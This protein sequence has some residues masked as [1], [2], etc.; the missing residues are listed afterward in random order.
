VFRKVRLD[1]LDEDAD[2]LAYWKTRTPAERISEV[3]SLR[4]LWIEV[5]DDPD[6]P[7]ELVAHRRRLGEPAIQRPVGSIRGMCRTR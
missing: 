1:Q 6:L 3:E 4:R 7:M 5:T 2:R